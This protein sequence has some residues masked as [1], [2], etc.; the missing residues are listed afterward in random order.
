MKNQVSVVIVTK[1]RQQELKHC[2]GSL[3]TQSIA[4][5][6]LIVVDNQSS[7][8]TK[9][10]VKAFSKTVSF[11]VKYILETKKGYPC[12]YNRGFKAASYPWVAFIDDDC[13][14]DQN[15]FASIL[16]AVKKHSSS[17]VILGRS[18][19][20]F[21]ENICSLVT[22]FFDQF[23]KEGNIRNRQVIDFEILDNKNIAYNMSFLHRHRLDYD[24]SRVNIDLGSSEDCDLG[25]QL[26]QAGGKA[27]YEPNMFIKHKDPIQFGSYYRKLFGRRAGHRSY[28]Q[29]WIEYRMK[30][31][32]KTQNS[33]ISFFNKFV[34][35]NQLSGWS[36]FRLASHVFITLMIA[37]LQSLIF[38]IRDQIDKSKDE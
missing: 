27:R 11:P 21:N 17:A 1:N 9:V 35:D 4:L 12:I 26:H 8:D 18:G 37:K 14:A 36:R 15:W 33:L 38:I 22:L 3:A 30:Q 31:N 32:F 34:L 25:M 29:K 23:W 6:E 16:M 10:I 13:I 20:Y 28:E 7:D 24:E 2:L 5:N 19:T